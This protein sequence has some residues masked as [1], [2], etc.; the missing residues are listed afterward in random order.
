MTNLNF[1]YKTY[2]YSPK[3][4]VYS[5]ALGIATSW[6]GWLVWSVIYLIAACSLL[7]TIGVENGVAAAASVALLAPFINLLCGIKH[8]LAEMID[9]VALYDLIALSRTAK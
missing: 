9:N 8:R 1:K 2:S 7:H 3:A 4:T 5:H 6:L